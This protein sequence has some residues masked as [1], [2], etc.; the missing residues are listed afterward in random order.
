MKGTRK[1]QYQEEVLVRHTHSGITEGERRGDCSVGAFFEEALAPHDDEASSRDLTRREKAGL[2]LSVVFVVFFVCCYVIFLYLPKCLLSVIECLLRVEWTPRRRDCLTDCLTPSFLGRT[3]DST[4][5]AGVRFLI[6]FLVLLFSLPSFLPLPVFSASR[7]LP[8]LSASFLFTSS[9]AM[10][11]QERKLTRR[12]CCSP[13]NCLPDLQKPD[14]TSFVFLSKDHAR[15]FC[16]ALPSRSPLPSLVTL[17]M[18]A[19]LSPVF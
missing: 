11:A 2:L 13:H 10:R 7:S 18:R 16:S 19:S 1:I 6:L 9:P 3:R 5:C 8:V 14:Q 4:A 17:V 12:L 15:F